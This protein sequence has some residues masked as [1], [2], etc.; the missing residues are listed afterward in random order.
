LAQS[1]ENL[2]QLL[3]Q[4]RA[5]HEE[6]K[7]AQLQIIQAAKMES[8]GTLAAGVAHEVKNPLQT[9]LMGVDYLSRN[10]APGNANFALALTDMRDAVMRA[11]AIVGELLQFSAATQFS[12]KAEDLN[13]LIERSFWL[14]QTEANSLQTTVVRHL[15]PRLPPVHVDRGKIEQVLI[16]LLLNALQAMSPGGT[17]KVSSRLVRVE[18]AL[19]TR[20]GIYGRFQPGDQ[21]A[22]VEIEDNGPGVREADLPRLFDPFFTTK[23][24]G[25]GTGL[26]LSVVRRIM[27]LHEGAI[28]IKNRSPHG[29]RVTLVL[30]A[31]SEGES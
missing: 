7:A 30:K 19:Q 27:D 22:V 4:L 11:N 15:A 29:V 23:P 16:N 31:Q 18:P 8:I 20:E 12:R 5:S 10:I 13:A 24:V 9:M 14:L 3:R 25:V 6:L 1:D 26:G 21:V 2:K 28:E 17:L